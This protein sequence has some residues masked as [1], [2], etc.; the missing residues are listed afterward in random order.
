MILKWVVERHFAYNLK[1]S[2]DH[3]TVEI[4]CYDYYHCLHLD[5]LDWPLLT[6]CYDDDD[7]VYHDDLDFYDATMSSRP[8]KDF[9]VS[10]RTCLNQ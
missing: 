1:A 5:A 6:Y 7:D 10:E 4:A 8:W 2:F 3:L 9:V